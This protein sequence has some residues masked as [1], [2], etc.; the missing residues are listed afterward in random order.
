MTRTPPAYGSDVIADLLVDLGVPHLAMNPGASFRGLHDSLVNRTAP[1]APDL[2]TVLHEA[3]AVAIAH[4]YAKVT[5][6]PMGVI[7][8][9]NV[10]LMNAVM[11]LY[12][13]WADRVP[14]LVLGA[15]GAV[16]AAARRPWIEWIHTSRDQGALIRSFVKWD[17]QP[18][19]LPAA[20]DAILRGWAMTRTAP[21]APVH[22]CLDTVLQEAAVTGSP[23][24]ADPSRHQ[25]PA[26]AVPDAAALTRAAQMLGAAERPL[27]LVGR[28]LRDAAGWADRIALAERAGAMVLCDQ[29]CGVGFPG[30]HP[31]FLAAPAQYPCA[32]SLAAV[33]EADL[34]LSLDWPD[35]AGLLSQRP[36]RVP[37][38]VVSADERLHNGWSF[39]HFPPV[40]ADLRIAVP[41]EAFTA[42]LLP[43]LPATTR[44]AW[45]PPAAPPP[46][47]PDSGPVTLDA[48]AAAFDRV[49]GAHP[50][51]L[52]RL[53]FG[54]PPE[55]MRFT[56][57]L[58]CIGFDGGG[59]IGSTPGITVGAALGLRGTGRLAVAI[60]GDGDL[61]MGSQALWT[62]AALKLPALFVVN[63]NRAFHNDVE[64]QERVA[65]HRSR[66]VE[67]RMV[68]MTLDDPPLD[69]P[70]LARAH[71]CV[72]LG[73]V[74]RIEELESALAE[75]FA[76]ARDG[77]TV[78][79]DVECLTPP[80]MR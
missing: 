17:D 39:D 1:A 48:L 4:G 21:C 71:G 5:G 18:A 24:V 8:H 67:N 64:H 37:T 73:P 78:V 45:L 3:Q 16:D 80:M 50:V 77:A 2:I 51:C 6:R 58:D 56:G 55:R 35:V 28:H 7:L 22:V 40:A 31:A 30:D 42:A 19:S 41:P 57:P 46:P 14:M 9:A 59:G 72:G 44:T 69:L 54:L 38:L 70:A 74:R 60:L 32:R 79:L 68:G 63:N 33:T 43:H 52:T 53:T 26:P 47:V 27:I 10:G 29:K 65:R 11:A 49:R 23:P 20:V 34:V 25:P 66:P 36:T 75:A 61:V 76:A 12:N 13:A 15:T 62:A